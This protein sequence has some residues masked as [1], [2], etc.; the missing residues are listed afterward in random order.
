MPRLSA[1]SAARNSD[2]QVA[3]V[4]GNEHGG[5]AGIARDVERM[6]GETQQEGGARLGAAPQLVG[7]GRVDADLEAGGLE[8][9]HGIL[10]VR[11]RRVRQ[12]AEID[13]VRAGSPHRHGAGENRIDAQRGGVDDLGKNAHVMAG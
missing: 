12:A 13:H 4:G 9:A 5:G 1:A 2:A 10:E 7:H 6:L 3:V 11:K 8:L